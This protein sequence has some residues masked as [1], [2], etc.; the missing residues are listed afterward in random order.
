[1]QLQRPENTGHFRAAPPS[2][3]RLPI[4]SK[5]KLSALDGPSI[6]FLIHDND[7]IFSDRVDQSIAA[8]G[9]EP[10]RTSLGSPWQNGTAERWVGTVKR[11]LLDHVL[12]FDEI[13]FRRLLREHVDY[14][15]KK[16]VHT[17][18]LDAPSG[19]PIPPKPGPSSRIIGSPRR[20]GLHHVY[21][22]RRAA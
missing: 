12:V 10:K 11:D 18:T 4:R 22:W 15:N 6:R 2:L 7:S 16:R 3:K 9:I 13:H 19:R 14:Y 1:M 20:G 5:W 17:V 8:F 21:E